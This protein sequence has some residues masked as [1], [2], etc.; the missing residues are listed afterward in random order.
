MLIKN[1]SLIREYP[2]NKSLNQLMCG[3]M[4]ARENGSWNYW[5][6][7]SCQDKINGI[8]KKMGARIS[9]CLS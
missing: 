6:T 8:K 3:L 7:E 1:G 4:V 2:V 5:A 9:W